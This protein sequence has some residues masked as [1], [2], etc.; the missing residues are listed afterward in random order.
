MTELQKLIVDGFRA[1]GAQ[2]EAAMVALIQLKTE[3]QQNQLLDW[4]LERGADNP[5]TQKELMEKV[6]EIAES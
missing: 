3:K 5:P 6:D 1:L 4:M 2:K